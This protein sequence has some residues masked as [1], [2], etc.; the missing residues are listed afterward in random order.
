MGGAMR[1]R[2][3]PPHADILTPREWEVLALL[4]GGLTNEQIAA[5]LDISLA[6]AKDHVS[7]ILSKLGVATREEAAAWQE[8]RRPWWRALLLWPSPK[9]GVAA[10][11]VGLAVVGL[12]L[13]GLLSADGEQRPSVFS[14]PT[15]TTISTPSP[16]PT[17]TPTVPVP[18]LTP[19]GPEQEEPVTMGAFG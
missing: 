13:W 1:R 12:V 19:P 9:A 4:R 14:L 18:A 17:A 6:T 5:R 2:G 8:P 15:A 10:T 16:T 11:V 3:R 7:E